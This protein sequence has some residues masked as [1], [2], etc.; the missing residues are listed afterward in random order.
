MLKSTGNKRR[1]VITGIGPVSANGIG[2][3]EFWEN[4]L[5]GKSVAERIPDKFRKYH[6]YKTD[7]YVPLPEIN[8]DDFAFI[9]KYARTLESTSIL[10]LTGT[11]LALMDAGFKTGLDEPLNPENFENSGILL[12]NGISSLASGFSFYSFHTYKQFLIDLPPDYPQPKFN[13]MVIPATMPDSASSW[14]SILFGIKAF[15]YTL[16][17]SCASGTYAIGEAFRKIK[18]GYADT[19]ITGG[20][21]GLNDE[22]GAILRGFDSLGTLTKSVDGRPMPF[23]RDRSGFL[24]AEGGGCILILEELEKAQ[25]RGTNI[26]AEIVDYQSNSDAHNIVQVQE[27]GEQITKLLKQIVG[28]HKIDYLN[29]HGTATELNDKVEQ[30]VILEIFGEKA[31]QPLINST[32][33]I[34]GHTIGASGAFEVAV[35]A[36]SLSDSKIHAN[37]AENTFEDLNLAS[38]TMNMK[39][40]CALKTSYGFGGHNAAMIIKKFEA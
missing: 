12:G 38:E 22:S 9:K 8:L 13:R 30:K 1:V 11:E 2:K 4:I 24:F 10:A 27:S 15:N 17:A 7:Y 18:D 14:V 35:T 36:L 28:N 33:S 5:S 26:Y 31:N 6:D 39:I 23:S 21:E 16:N 25:K 32:K 40:N 19:M 20:I 34:M 29:T 3:D 37:I